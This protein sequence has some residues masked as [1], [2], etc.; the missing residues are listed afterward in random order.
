MSPLYL[1]FFSYS[2]FIRKRPRSNGFFRLLGM[3]CLLATCF[4]LIKNVVVENDT[5]MTFIA[6]DALHNTS[7]NSCRL[8]SIFSGRTESY[9]PRCYPLLINFADGCCRRSQKNNCLTGL[10]YGIRQ[11]MMF[12]KQILKINPD[13]LARNRHIL[14]RKR[15]AGYWLWKPYIILRELYLAS[16]GDI[17]VYSDAAVDFVANISHLTK[18]TEKQDIIVFRLTG[19]KVSKYSMTR[20]L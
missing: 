4:L 11:C 13:F 5:P 14:R 20:L 19:W 18:L 3:S 10:Q 2:M 1:F 7:S 12:N 9:E 17:I 6:P 16:E 8:V 15:G